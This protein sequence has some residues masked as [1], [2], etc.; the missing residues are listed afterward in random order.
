MKTT[1]IIKL[2]SVIK[3]RIYLLYNYLRYNNT[4]AITKHFWRKHYYCRVSLK[5]KKNFWILIQWIKR[6]AYRGE[7]VQWGGVHTEKSGSESASTGALAPMPAEGGPRV[8]HRIPSPRRPGASWTRASRWE[9][10][11]STLSSPSRRTASHRLYPRLSP[12]SHVILSS[13][14]LARLPPSMFPR[15]I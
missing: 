13:P 6:Y 15:T 9:R 3:I 1:R 12:V 2:S 8:P 10:R 14:P 5:W 11:Q 4:A 7:A